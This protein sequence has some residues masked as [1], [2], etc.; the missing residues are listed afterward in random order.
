MEHA[1]KACMRE[2]VS[3]VR[4]PPPPYLYLYVVYRESVMKQAY[5]KKTEL[6]T[7]LGTMVAVSDD[8]GIYLLNFLDMKGLDKVL[9]K[10]ESFT[11]TSIIEGMTDPLV[12]LEKE[13]KG[14]FEGKLK[15]F[16]TPIHLIGTPFQKRALRVLLD[17]PYGE[18]R[19]Y[20]EQA[21]MAGNPTAFRAAANAN[22]TNRLCLLLPCHRIINSNG[23]LGGYGSGVARKKWLLEHEK[24]SKKNHC[25]KNI[26][27]I[28]FTSWNT[29]K[30]E[31]YE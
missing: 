15:T 13:L 25:K 2:I 20:A 19:S 7:P 31:S 16:N 14:Y 5:I 4:I 27:N 10:L 12:L 30:E 8:Q 9:K 24:N 3:W 11:R 18:T 29:K 6:E 22:G 28:K 23:E 26:E 17:I 1:W 21:E